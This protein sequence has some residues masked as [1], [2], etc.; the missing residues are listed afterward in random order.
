VFRPASARLTL[1][2]Q[3]V[4]V[5][6]C[7]QAAPSWASSGPSVPKGK[8]AARKPV[9]HV[10]VRPAELDAQGVIVRLA[11]GLAVSVPSGR[12]DAPLRGRTSLT[13]GGQAELSGRVD[14]AA[15]G[16]R[17][18]HATPL[19]DP[20]AGD[21]L[22][23]GLEGAFVTV[24]SRAGGAGGAGAPRSGSVLCE[25]V[26]PVRARVLVPAD[27]LTAEPRELVYPVVNEPAAKLA[28]ISAPTDLVGPGG[29]SRAKLERGARVVV[30]PGEA[31]GAAAV[32]GFVR[33]RTYGPFAIEGL[34]AKDLVLKGRTGADDG[35]LPA[36]PRKTGLTPTH[37][38]LAEAPAF[39]DPAGKRPIGTLRGGVLVSVGIE[40]SGPRVKVMTYG[41]VVGEMWVPS[42]ALRP[43]ERDIWTQDD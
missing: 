26:G 6:L 24:S 39:A 34:V 32:A 33:V 17:L 19:A 3:L 16:A 4:F 11:P 27:A 1:G 36:E 28:A 31:V 18:A 30:L 23:E 43:L 15:L 37:E 38:V 14:A 20:V 2:L 8:R 35:P 25:T 40:V 12:T 21:T 10:V 41:D 29:R 42:T 9:T 13:L 7:A 22:G 5:A